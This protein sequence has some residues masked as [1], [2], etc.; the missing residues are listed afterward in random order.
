MNRGEGEVP[1]TEFGIGFEGGPGSDRAYL[2]IIV[3]V[4]KRVVNSLFG[5]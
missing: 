2:Y 1:N 5:S 3:S 4:L